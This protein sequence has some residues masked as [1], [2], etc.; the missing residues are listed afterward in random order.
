MPGPRARLLVSG[1]LHLGRYPSRVPPGDP[2]LTLDAVVRSLVDQAVERRVDAVVLTGDVAD[3]SNK[4]FEAFGVLERALHRLVDAGVPV[5][6]V[7]GNHDHDV[8]GSV[9][10]AVGEGVRVLGRGETWESASIE[11]GGREVVRL[12]GW[13]FA[14]P[15]VHTSPLESLPADLGDVPAVGV[16]HG[17]LDVPASRYA[18]VALAD[19]WATGASAW[20]LGHIHAPR[21]EQR[22][23]HLVLYPGSP[24]PLDP[25]EPGEHGAWL[26]EITED[27]RASAELIPIATVRYEALAVDLD[28]AADATEIRQRAARVLRDFAETVREASPAVRR[29][30]VR[31][32]LKGRTPAYRAVER[33]ASEL[34]EDGETATGGLAVVVDRVED[35]ARPALDLAGLAEGSGPVATLAALAGRLE[36]GEPSEGDLALIRRGVEALQQARRAR[37]FEPLGR[38]DR[39]DADLA[40]EAAL[41]LRRQTYRM[42]DEV[43]SQRPSEASAP[44]SAELPAESVPAVAAPPS[45]APEPPAASEGPGALPEAEEVVPTDVAD[46]SG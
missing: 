26:V 17:D 43:L 15:Y 40:A 12:W 31:L 23:G 7:A 18:P 8:L 27:G 16:L 46:A 2:A 44:A 28:G 20:L 29:A 11:K 35:L 34:V 37:V 22:D 14:G 4:Y 25:G 21:T 10:E 38:S 32:T 1:D 19:L 6:A 30:V 5:V 33:V 3:Q 9:A 39:L 13:S 41:R 24:Q 36:R 45:A 42:L